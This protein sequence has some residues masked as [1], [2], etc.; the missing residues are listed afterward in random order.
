MTKSAIVAAKK[1]VRLDMVCPKCGRTPRRR[2]RG[3][4]P[5]LIG[6]I[7]DDVVHGLGVC[8]DDLLAAAKRTRP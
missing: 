5:E 2:A 8:T 3:G 1:G 7:L 6:A 4:P